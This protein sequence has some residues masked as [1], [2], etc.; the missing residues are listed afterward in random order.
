[1]RP[2][3]DEYDNANPL[4]NNEGVGGEIQIGCLVYKLEGAV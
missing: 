3:Q 4:G 1:M 2:Y